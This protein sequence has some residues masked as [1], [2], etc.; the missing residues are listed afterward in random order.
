[1]LEGTLDVSD[2]VA[3][4]ARSYRR[5]DEAPIPVRV[6]IS[7]EPA[8]GHTLVTVRCADFVGR[9]AQIVGVL[10]D[11]S[12]DIHYAKLDTRGREVIDSFL[13][14]RD[15]HPVRDPKERQAL[16]DTMTAALEG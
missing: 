12:C 10:Y 15:G 8:T 6:A 14:R 5:T 4:R 11:A 7:D 1:M 16:A 13:V 3:E 9:L 2:R